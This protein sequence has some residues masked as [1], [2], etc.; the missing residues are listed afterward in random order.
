MAWDMTIAARVSGIRRAGTV[1]PTHRVIGLVL[2]SQHGQGPKLQL[3]S[4]T[5]HLHPGHTHSPDGAALARRGESKGL[6]VS[7]LEMCAISTNQNPRLRLFAA[8]LLCSARCS[9]AT[10]SSLDARGIQASCLA[11]HFTVLPARI[12]GAVV[13]PS[14][15]KLF[16][17]VLKQITV[18][19]AMETLGFSNR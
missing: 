1:L 16:E 17:V 8:T 10:S 19:H 11:A 3:F 5:P 2:S 12:T 14:T 7:R 18:D 6:S 4:S 13:A 9:R 15:G